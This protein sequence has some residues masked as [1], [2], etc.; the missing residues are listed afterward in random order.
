MCLKEKES[1][2][3]NVVDK[4]VSGDR[5]W[6]RSAFGQTWSV[7]CAFGISPEGCLRPLAACVNLGGAKLKGPVGRRSFENKAFRASWTQGSKPGIFPVGSCASC[8]ESASWTPWWHD[9]PTAQ[10]KEANMFFATT[11]RCR[12]WETSQWG[13]SLDVGRM[14]SNGSPIRYQDGE[15]VAEPRAEWKGPKTRRN[16]SWGSLGRPSWK[17]D[18]FSEMPHIHIHKRN[19]KSVFSYATAVMDKNWRMGRRR[20]VGGFQIRSMHVD[21]HKSRD[22]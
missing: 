5:C 8:L 15:N 22:L 10:L 21:L 16:T 2:M 18:S 19:P 1:R 17:T 7:T 20:K 11:S 9:S 14:A 3:K 12:D 4:G 13:C 6:E